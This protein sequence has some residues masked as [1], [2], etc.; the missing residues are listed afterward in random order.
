MGKRK[1]NCGCGLYLTPV[2]RFWQKV[3]KTSSCWLWTAALDRDGYGKIG[4]NGKSIRSHRYSYELHKGEL[5]G[6]MVVDHLCKVRNCVN[7]AHLRIVTWVQN[8]FENSNSPARINRDKTQC[9]HGHSLK[10][11][12]LYVQPKTGKRYCK[13]CDRR[14][15][16]EYQR[17][18]AQLKAK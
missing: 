15:A 3:D 1:C 5:E 2:E 13:I 9:K 17:R 12:N 7:P 18:K 8:I 16:R 4:V 14:R 11:N 6:G 10:G